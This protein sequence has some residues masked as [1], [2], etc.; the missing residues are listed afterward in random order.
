MDYD[1]AIRCIQNK[2]Y[3]EA[4]NYMVKS[5]LQDKIHPLSKRHRENVTI[6]VAKGIKA[7][8]LELKKRYGDALKPTE[9][10]EQTYSEVML[11]LK[12]PEPANHRTL[13]EQL[14]DD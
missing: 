5:I 8:H 4:A 10:A 1:N 3:E 11:E 12:S 6:R 7:K 9:I 14:E 13:P 2:R